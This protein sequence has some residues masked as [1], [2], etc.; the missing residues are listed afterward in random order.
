[1]HIASSSVRGFL[2]VNLHLLIYTVNLPLINVNLQEGFE[3][4]WVISAKFTLK[5]SK[6]G[7]DIQPS[8]YCIIY[9]G[10]VNS[11]SSTEDTFCYI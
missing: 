4:I 8:D 1:M 11:M 6:R 10:Y 5:F 7:M 9:E 2:S 3:D